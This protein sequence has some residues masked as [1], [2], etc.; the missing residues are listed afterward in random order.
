MARTADPSMSHRAFTQLQ[1]GHAAVEAWLWFVAALVFAMVA[2]G[3]ATRLT[4]SGLSI[5]EWQPIMGAIPPLHEADWLVA[6]EKY[7]QIPQ[8]KLVNEGMSLAEFKSIFWWEW[9]HRFLG[10]IVGIVFGLPLVFFWLRGW[11][12]SGTAGKYAGLLALGAIQGAIGWYM[13]A[14]GL[15]ERTSVSQYRLA[16]HL[17]GALAIFALLV[18]L[19]LDERRARLGSASSI[20]TGFVRTTAAVIVAL[21]FVQTV[22]GAFV[23]GLKAGLIYNTWPDMNGQFVPADYWID[24]HG[25]ISLFESH[26]AAQ[27]NHRMMA[28][29]VLAAALVQGIAIWRDG[30]TGMAKSSGLLLLT[31]IVAQVIIGIATLLWHV[32]VSLGVLHQASAVVVL[33]YA[34]W[35]LFA[36][37]DARR[38]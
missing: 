21:I 27:F 34:V 38:I 19:A 25:L 32:P 1:D 24:G 10:R 26:A 30:V 17:T 31:V 33:G 18:W 13:V 37:R 15:V 2:V 23:A 7:K 8:Y 6:F 36:V 16:L 29:A 22:L 4:G 14:S 3:G 9:G 28:Y 5:T 20:V 11:L 35:H 12:R